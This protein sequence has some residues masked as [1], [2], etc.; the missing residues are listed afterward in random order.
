[1]VISVVGKNRKI[2]KKKVLTREGWCDI[3]NKLSGEAAGSL[4]IE[5]QRQRCSEREIRR[6]M[7]WKNTYKDSENSF[8]EK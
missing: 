6:R 7:P 3:I 1:M 5:Q 4:K 2:N 8:E